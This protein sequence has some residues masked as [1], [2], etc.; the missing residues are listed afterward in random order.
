MASSAY[1]SLADRTPPLPPLAPPTP[2]P[3]P[4]ASSRPFPCTQGKVRMGFP[5][6][7]RP[8][9]RVPR[10]AERK[11][12]ASLKGGCREPRYSAGRCRG[13]PPVSKNVGGRSGRDSGARQARPSAQE[14]RRP[15]QDHPSPSPPHRPRLHCHTPLAKY[16]LLCYGSPMKW[17]AGPLLFLGA[18]RIHTALE[19]KHRA[20]PCGRGAEGTT[21]GARPSE[22]G[23]DRSQCR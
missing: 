21:Q 16:E 19:A 6:C 12:C 14:G 23:W 9:Q 4:R 10:N 13:C 1:E 15:R 5:L 18:C 20:S 2:P 8:A 17:A 7:P 3:A 11:P 22:K